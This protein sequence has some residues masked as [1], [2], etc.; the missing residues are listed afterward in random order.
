M[1]PQ[2]GWLRRQQLLECANMHHAFM[3]SR[4][5]NIC[6][7]RKT[8]VVSEVTSPLCCGSRSS[9]LKQTSQTNLKPVD[10]V[11]KDLIK[12]RHVCKSF[13]FFYL[14][15]LTF[16]GFSGC[17]EGLIK[18]HCHKKRKENHFFFCLCILNIET[19]F[20]LS[21]KTILCVKTHK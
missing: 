7:S 14:A 19:V 9:R 15:V 4:I 20:F 3:C 6:P 16:P 12:G 17:N 18:R 21:L 13:F 1:R 5:Y 8:D 11:Q 2:N 10:G